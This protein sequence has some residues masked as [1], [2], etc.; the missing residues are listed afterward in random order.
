MTIPPEQDGP[1]LPVAAVLR[2]APERIARLP[3]Y[4][5]P[6]GGGRSI[7]VRCGDLQPVPLARAGCYMAFHCH[8][9][10]IGS[11]HTRRAASPV[12]TRSVPSDFIPSVM[13][14]A[15]CDE[16]TERPRPS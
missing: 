4:R 16:S 1:Y 10:L 9:S 13:T 6:D 5:C 3:T 2:F 12:S 11:S 7:Q 8:A 15:R 14:I